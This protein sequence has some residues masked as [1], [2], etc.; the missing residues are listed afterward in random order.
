[1]PKKKSVFGH[2]SDEDEPSTPAASFGKNSNSRPNM[3]VELMARGLN[4]Q[5][6]VATSA[7]MAKDEDSSIYQYDEVYDSMQGSKGK[8]KQDTQDRKVRIK[9]S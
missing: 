5:K 1:M 4:S 9:S 3:N 7:G 6:Q 2:E 8:R